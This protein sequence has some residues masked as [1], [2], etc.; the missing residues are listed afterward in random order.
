MGPPAR[1]GS[2]GSSTTALPRTTVTAADPSVRGAG[3]NPGR[4]DDPRA[5]V[6]AARV[7]A[8]PRTA[9]TSAMVVPATA[10][11]AAAEVLASVCD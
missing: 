6:A 1:T 5:P 8:T 7:S 3:A 4:A 10:P 11:E 2:A 9:R